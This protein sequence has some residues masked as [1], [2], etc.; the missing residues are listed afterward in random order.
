MCGIVGFTSLLSKDKREYILDKQISILKH[1]GPDGSGKYIDEHIALGHTRLA[2]IDIEHAKQPMISE[3]RRYVLIFNGEIYN[4]IELRQELGAK[5]YKFRTYSDTEVLLN[6]FI[7][8]KEECLNKLNGMFAFAVYDT[9]T[10]DVFLARDH[11]GIKPL[12]YTFAD[13]GIVFASEVKAILAYPGATKD[14]DYEAI[15]EYITFQ[16]TFNERTLFKDI[17][18]LEPATYMIVNKNKILHKH[19]YWDLNYEIDTFH[20]KEYFLSEIQY[21]LENSVSIQTRADVKV[22]TH[23]SGGIDSSIVATFA[24]KIYD[25]PMFAF[26]GAFREGPE[27]DETHYSKLVA[28]NIGCYHKIIYPSAQDF[29]DNFE[30]ILYYMDYPEAGPGVFPQYMVSQL[31][32]QHVKVVLGGQGGDELFGGYIRYLVAY[33]EQALK[34]AIFQTQEEGKY[35]VTLQSLIPNLHQLKDYI[36]M[37]RSQFEEGLFEPMDRRYFR[38]INRSLSASRLYDI[39]VSSQQETLFE[40][41]Q[42]IFNKPDTRSL[43]NKMTYFDLKTLLPALLHIEDRVSMAHSLESRVPILDRRL[44]ELVATIPPTMKFEGG[45]IKH[46]LIEAVKNFLPE[47]VVNRKDKKGFPTPINLW[48]SGE[49]KDFVLDILLSKEAKER[50]L[51]NVNEVENMLSKLGKFNRDLWGLLNLELWFRIYIDGQA[52]YNN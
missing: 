19:K 3:D 34:G 20:T 23:L 29:L 26:S 15:N 39:D 35:V 11:F 42:S 32:S 46:M 6:A 27:Y 12:Y 51:Y 22:G 14:V 18:R 33:L 5:G 13:D 25:T 40:K 2:I 1:R 24:S 43:F 4:Y 10:K 9:E 47:E 17:Y 41:F 16:F 36:P 45:R 48:L 7:E 21:I 30:K 44:A 49:L 52:T 8:Y 37:I 50:G 28:S 38:L 31:A